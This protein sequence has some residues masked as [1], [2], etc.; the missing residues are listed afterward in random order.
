M[1]PTELAHLRRARDLLDR[2]YA[3]PLDVPTMA[4]AALM[5]PAHFSRRFR[6]AFGETPHG[7]LQTRRVERAMAL[8]RRGDP[9]V[10][11]VCFDVGFT[12][13][14]SFSSTFA[15]LVGEPPTTY[16]AP[17]PR[18]ARSRAAVRGEGLDATEQEWRSARRGR[19][20][21]SRPCRLPSPTLPSTSPISTRRWASTPSASAS[22]SAWTPRPGPTMRWLTVA[23]PGDEHELLLAAVDQHVPPVDRDAMRELVAKGTLAVFVQVDDVDEVF[24]SLR[25]AGVEILQEPIDQPYG[26]RGLRRPR[27][28]REPPAP[29]PAAGRPGL[30]GPGHARYRRV[31]RAATGRSTRCTAG[32]GEHITVSS[33]KRRANALSHAAPRRPV[34]RLRAL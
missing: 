10:T 11:E 24:E 28:E 15:R 21:A 32:G 17:R 9:S 25:G 20:V 13:L 16:R 29:Q 8:L 22:R 31:S 30:S 18:R 5:S 2:E 1:D 34:G 3:R 6:E 14:G 33:L 26:I 7:Y 19:R 12:S 23:A 4:R 27:P